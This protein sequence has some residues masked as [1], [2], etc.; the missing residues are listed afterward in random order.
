MRGGSIQT[1]TKK[2]KKNNVI[3]CFSM[4]ISKSEKKNHSVLFTKG[5]KKKVDNKI[6]S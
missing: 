6:K 4:P 1:P 3:L 5:V 2:V